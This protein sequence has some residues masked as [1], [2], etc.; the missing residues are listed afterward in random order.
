MNK[1]TKNHLSLT[2]YIYIRQSAQNQV[3]HNIESKRRQ[4][5]L[6]NKAL[7]YGFKDI[8]IID[9]DLGKSGSGNCHREGFERLLSDVCKGK[10]GAIFALEASRLARNGREWHTL[11][12]M[13]ALVNTLIIDYEGIYDP[14]LINDRL[15]LGMKG[16]ISEMKLSTLRQRSHE[17]IRK[18]SVVNFLIQ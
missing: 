2:A 14:K 8:Q 1:I 9:N 13:C 18:Q 10:A 16:T 15:L 4:Y 7:E 17:A 3:Q 11:L 5:N 12:E 6:K